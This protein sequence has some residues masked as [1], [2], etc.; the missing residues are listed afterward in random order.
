MYRQYEFIKIW[1]WF[2]IEID[3]YLFFRILKLRLKEEYIYNDHK[4]FIFF[5]VNVIISLMNYDEYFYRFFK[6]QY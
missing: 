6:E 5:S 1:I 4:S 2:W 3:L